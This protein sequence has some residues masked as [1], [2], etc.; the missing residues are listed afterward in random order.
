[1]E[2]LSHS[3]KKHCELCKTPFRFTK[4][5][6][7]QMPKTLPAFVFATHIAK[8]VF[9]NILV[10]LRAGLVVSV[11]LGWLPYLMRSVWSFLFWISDEGFGTSPFLF[12]RMNTTSRIAS[13]VQHLSALPAAVCPTSP[14]FAMSASEGL[15]CCADYATRAS[16][17]S[18]VQSRYGI[19]LTS[20]ESLYTALLRTALGSIGLMEKRTVGFSNS[21]LTHAVTAQAPLVP[22]SLLGEV[23][24][25]RNL[26]RYSSIN[27]IV[28]SVLEGQLITVLV[29][30]CFILIILVRDYVVQ[31][32]PEVNVRAGFANADN[33]PPAPPQV[34]LADPHGDGVDHLI[35]DRNESGDEEDLP[36]EETEPPL[37]RYAFGPETEQRMEELLRNAPALPR[38]QSRPDGRTEAEAGPSSRPA[39]AAS[40]AA[41]SSASP[42]SSR[43]IGNLAVETVSAQSRPSVS[44]SRLG[45]PPSNDSEPQESTVH[46]YL[47][48]YREARGD[49][50][51]ILKIVKEEHLEDRLDYWVALT[52]QKI[53]RSKAIGKGAADAE[54]SSSTDKLSTRTDYAPSQS[55]RS[56][57]WEWPSES[58]GD[59]SLYSGSN[60][61]DKGKGIDADPLG[62]SI[63]MGSPLRPR[64]NTDGPRGHEGVNPFGSN[65]WS[66]SAISREIESAERENGDSGSWGYP[67]PPSS[68]LAGSAS[69]T[70]AR[71]G[72]ANPP[73]LNDTDGIQGPRPQPTPP[74]RPA[75]EGTEWGNVPDFNDLPPTRPIQ[76]DAD[77]PPRGLY[78]QL[79]HFMFQE[80]DV[81]EV[82][83]RVAQFV[84]DGPQDNDG[85]FGEDGDV[86]EEFEQEALE[87]AVAAGLDP[88]AI[89]DAEDLEGVM[90]LLGMRGPVAGLFQNAIFCVFLVSVTI[91]LGIFV[92]YNFGRFSIWVLANPIQLVLIFFG[93]LRILQDAA[94]VLGG[95]CL[96]GS[97][98][99]LRLAIQLC[100]RIVGWRLVPAYLASTVLASWNMT[101]SATKRITDTFLADAP[102]ISAGEI[103]NFSAVSHQALLTLKG[104]VAFL[105]TAVGRAF[106]FVLGCDYSKAAELP[107]A[108]GNL[109][110]VAWRSVKEAPA[111]LSNPR[112]WVIGLTSSDAA[113]SINPEL[114]YWD[115]TD[116]FWAIAVGYVALCLLAAL[117]LRR[118]APFST[119][120]AGRELEA[121]IIDGLNQASGVMKVILIIGIEMLIFPLYCGLLLDAALLPLFEDATLKSRVLFTLHYPLTS[122][123]VHW[124]VGTGYMFHFALFVSMCR[125]IMRKGVLCK[126]DGK[127]VSCCH[128]LALHH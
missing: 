66:F 62:D 41:G 78:N 34:I 118:G 10:W 32:Q 11:W 113:S 125:K 116:R 52:K 110:T 88:E 17:P 108:V 7:P 84:D 120:Q 22:L 37:A 71:A 12:V 102:I 47:R 127:V 104:H 43:T 92:P 81:H 8:Y 36:Q 86:A 28:I 126:S 64:A 70:L 42:E 77:E 31:Q 112:M 91:F 97:L 48:V 65:N 44:D 61:K 89:E 87:A 115:G 76:L 46:E 23:T 1:M 35:H 21:T 15:M 63:M 33:P 69:S 53:E 45:D 29:V 75:T 38:R 2:W 128:Y 58:L 103:H 109:S 117:Y 98:Y 49:P 67:T 74:E 56:T 13:E 122:I 19:N 39:T 55:D 54:T 3:Q 27:N 124:F 18:T 20:G 72:S 14:L 111:V 123:F 101:A 79:V 85:D 73:D 24:F 90:E 80:V 68:S 96:S 4:L 106:M 59:G 57:D 114:A 30:V 6:D 121:S 50:D 94:V 105:F 95:A 16:I 83:I 93:L 51:E 40:R 9:R 99:I 60:D 107:A 5:Y 82:R 100:E 25:L 26:T 119:G